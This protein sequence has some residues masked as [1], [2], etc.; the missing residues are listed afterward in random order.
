MLVAILLDGTGTE[1]TVDIIMD[2]N[3]SIIAETELISG[4][5]YEL[6]TNFIGGGTGSIELSP[7]GSI[8]CDGTPV[9][10]TVIPDDDSQFVAWS[11][12]ASGNKKKVDIIMN[13]DK[14][15]VAEFDII[16][17]VEEMNQE[18]SNLIIY[19]NPFKSSTTLTYTLDTNSKVSLSIYNSTGSLVNILVSKNQS[20]GD[21]SVNW[22]GNSSTG[23]NLPQGLYFGALDISNRKSQYIKILLI[24]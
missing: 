23:V 19:P 8:Y 9:S 4:T 17:A 13:G 7:E 20:P 1:Q 22:N 18:S 5:D 2:G 11:G 14:S 24:K 16:E 10:A 15:I 6:T 21:Y 12:D 3:K